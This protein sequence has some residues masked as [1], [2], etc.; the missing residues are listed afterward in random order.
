MRDLNFCCC[1]VAI[2]REKTKQN[3]NVQTS[4]HPHDATHTYTYVVRFSCIVEH[5]FRVFLAPETHI[6][7][8][9]ENRTIYERNIV[10]GK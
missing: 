1:Y 3:A 4:R 9:R 7:Q 8:Q 5:V 6:H 10:D 2:L